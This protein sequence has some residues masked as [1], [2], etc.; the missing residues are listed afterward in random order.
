MGTRSLTGSNPVREPGADPRQRDG[1]PGRAA[2]INHSFTRGA[3]RRS[4]RF[5]V[6]SK[7]TRRLALDREDAEPLQLRLWREPSSERSCA[8][9]AVLSSVDEKDRRARGVLLAVAN[10]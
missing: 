2:A 7:D 1:P 4:S 5:G 6:T 9:Q 3:A 8:A 10:S